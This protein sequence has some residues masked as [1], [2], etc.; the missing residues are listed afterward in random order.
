[1]LSYQH[2]YHAG[3]FA[4]NLAEAGDEAAAMLFG[5]SGRH[6]ARMLAMAKEVR[7]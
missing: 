2:G 5:S 7:A 1:M 4:D 3:N 6:E